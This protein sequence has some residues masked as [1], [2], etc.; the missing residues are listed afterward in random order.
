[1]GV[2]VEV[3]AIDEYTVAFADRFSVSFQ[4]YPEN[5]FRESSTPPRSHGAL[6]I[7]ITSPRSGFLPLREGEA[8]WL[9]VLAR[10]NSQCAVKVSWL[11]PSG[12]QKS[13][14]PCSAVVTSFQ[15]VSGLRNASGR[16]LP[17]IRFPLSAACTPCAGVR[18]STSDGLGIDVHFV[19]VAEF[20]ARTGRPAPGPMSPD[21]SYGGWLLP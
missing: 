4:R 21:D 19:T 6:P 16:L 15:V 17:F 2:V 11:D 1:L 9:G 3:T 18:I 12:A 5:E 7:E 20:E 8:V 14:L 10:E 13:P